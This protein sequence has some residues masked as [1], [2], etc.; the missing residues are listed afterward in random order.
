V[1]LKLKTGGHSNEHFSRVIS[2]CK[3]E[4]PPSKPDSLAGGEELASRAGS[5]ETDEPVATAKEPE[6][7]VITL[8]FV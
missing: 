8:P 3:T 5:E 2:C 4:A 6:N 1:L 7:D